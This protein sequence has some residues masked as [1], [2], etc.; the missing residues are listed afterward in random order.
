MTSEPYKWVGSRPVRPDGGPK[1]TG[2]ARY[3]ADYSLP[4]MLT[5]RVLRSP[6]AHARIKGIDASKALALP[7]VR[8]VITGADFPDQPFRYMGPSRVEQNLWHLT[9]N[10]MAR[11]KALYEGH[12]VAAVAAI[13]ASTAEA[14]LALIDVT[15]EVLPHV[16]DVEAAMADE[17]AFERLGCGH[18]DRE[19]Q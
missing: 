8:A 15:Y 1:V 14:A 9:R 12:A 11:E 19:E 2:Q 6:H 18:A 13:D 10:V 17:E 3:G 7:G 4:G 16:I 5:G